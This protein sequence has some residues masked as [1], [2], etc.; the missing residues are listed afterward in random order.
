MKKYLELAIDQFFEM[1]EDWLD[2]D[3]HC[4]GGTKKKYYELDGVKFELK[5]D[6]FWEKAD[7]FDYT[8]IDSNGTELDKGHWI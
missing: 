2:G 6:G 4:V 3:R 7:W 1:K 8:V 5:V